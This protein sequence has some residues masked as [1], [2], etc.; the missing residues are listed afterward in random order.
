MKALGQEHIVRFITAFRR[1]GREH[2]EHYICF[3]WADGGTLDD[4]WS[5]FPE[6]R[7]SSSLVRAVVDQLHGLAQALRAAHYLQ[8]TDEES[9]QESYIHGDIKPSNILWF[10]QGGE[11]GTLKI[12]DWGEAKVY[13]ANTATRERDTTARYGTRRYEPPEVETGL[14]VDSLEPKE[15]RSRLYDIWSFGCLTFEFLAWLLYG[16]EG[17][18]LFARDNVGDYGIS[19]SFYEMNH[20]GHAKVHGVANHWMECMA[21]DPHCRIGGSALGDILDIVRH[22]L[23]IAKLPQGGGSLDGQVNTF[24]RFLNGGLDMLKTSYSDA[25]VPEPDP[26]E[27]V[28]VTGSGATIGPTSISS[29]TPA[30][31]D[32]SSRS[33]S[34][35]S[36]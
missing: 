21:D 10:K 27:E 26:M 14:M 11:I 22:G 12:A 18:K 2:L 36:S 20:D 3:E 35:P 33:G 17:L 29:A 31:A 5:T 28:H 23:L 6:P 32:C 25:K 16:K 8:S 34:V 9:L 30:T 7:L 4:L 24:S 13:R 1:G 19:D 15:T